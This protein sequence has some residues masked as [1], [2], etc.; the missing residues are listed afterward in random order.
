M[1]LWIFHLLIFIWKLSEFIKNRY[2]YREILKKLSYNYKEKK[3]SLKNKRYSRLK[4]RKKAVETTPI[5]SFLS[6]MARKQS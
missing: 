3:I 4:L 5:M 6:T 2:K 1:G